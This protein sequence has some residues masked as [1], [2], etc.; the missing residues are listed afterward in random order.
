MS[1][2][3][4]LFVS[5]GG[6][7][8]NIASLVYKALI[9][10]GGCEPEVLALTVAGDIFARNQ[11]PYTTLSHYLHL[12]KDRDEILSGGKRW[13][14][15][16]F[17][18]NSN[19]AY[20]ECIAYLGM[21][22]RDLRNRVGE[23]QAEREFLQSG[24]RAVCA[25]EAMKSILEFIGPDVV[26][27]TCG[28]RMEKAAGLAANVLG[29]PIVRIGDLP[30]FDKAEYQAITCVMNGYAR[31]FAINKLEIPS[32]M[33]VVTGSPVFEENLQITPEEIKAGAE[34]YKIQ[35][36]RKVVLFLEEPG[37]PEEMTDIE[38]SLSDIAKKYKD[39]LFVFKYHPNQDLCEDIWLSENILRVQTA[40]LKP[41][42]HLCSVAITKDSTAGVE[43]VLIDKPLINILLS[44]P[45]CD[46]SEY[47][48]SERV[49][50]LTYLEQSLLQCLDSN[51]EICKRQTAARKRFGN[52]IHAAAHISDVIC[53]A[54]YGHNAAVLNY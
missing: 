32:S 5:Y 7:H 48:I 41:L 23:E 8:A 29:V 21:G 2:I 31:D 33:V 15:K 50:D 53:A 34:K 19:M 25:V 40:P 30:E 14:E 37:M 20:E 17:N 39:I 1:K 10:R 26:V 16:F 9:E 45:E 13:A 6:G 18:S 22:F 27:L 46:F 52:G 3:K 28:V 11:I 4:P 44:P 12:F 42:L 49:C 38:S 36:F 24:R 47:G 35:N 54:A 51:S 43:A